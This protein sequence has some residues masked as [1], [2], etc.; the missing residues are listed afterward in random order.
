MAK[1]ESDMHRRLRKAQNDRDALIKAI[2]NIRDNW[3]RGNLAGAVT[4]AVSLADYIKHG[5]WSASD[6]ANIEAILSAG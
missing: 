4:D 5:E 3:E 2:H 1:H 6:N